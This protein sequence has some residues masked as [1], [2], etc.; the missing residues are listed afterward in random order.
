VDFTLLYI[1]IGLTFPESAGFPG[2]DNRSLSGNSILRP[3]SE[4][5][6]PNTSG[7]GR[8]PQLSI[9]LTNTQRLITLFSL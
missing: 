8:Q 9:S 5:P 4:E 6:N 1:T 2:K 3:T 7:S